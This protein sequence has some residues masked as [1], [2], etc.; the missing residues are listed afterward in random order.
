[1]NM[2]VQGGSN[3]KQKHQMGVG[4]G[5]VQ[6]KPVRESAEEDLKEKES[7]KVGM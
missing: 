4:C 2:C 3:L 6:T 7:F 1:M 5:G